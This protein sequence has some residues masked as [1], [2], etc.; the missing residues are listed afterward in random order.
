MSAV[1]TDFLYFDIFS[2]KIHSPGAGELSNEQTAA[3][4]VK[5]V[6]ENRPLLLIAPPYPQLAALETQ[7]ILS[8]PGQNLYMVTG[9]RQK[10]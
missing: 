3:T 5:F 7:L 2:K 10:Y 8:T 6:A 9:V 4:V 1:D